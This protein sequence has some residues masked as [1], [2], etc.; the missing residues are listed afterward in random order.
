MIWVTG[1]RGLIGHYVVEFAST[2]NPAK[3]ARPIARPEVE[4]TDFKL[5]ERLF[6]NENP[7]A[8]IHCAALSKTPVCQKD[9]T[10]AREQ[11][12]EVTAFLSDLAADI[13]FLFFS[14]DLVFDGRQGNYRED[15]GVNPLSVY[16]ETKVEAELVV[17]RNPRHAVIRTSLNGGR[18]PTGNRGFNEEMRAAWNRGETTRLFVDE[19]RSP[20]AAI[21]TARATWELLC[22]GATGVYHVAGTQRLSRFQIGE[23]IAA[24]WPQLNPRLEAA[25]LK[26]YKGAPR[27]PDTSLDCAKAQ[28][29][30]SFKLPGLTEWL[31]EHPEMDF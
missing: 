15:A 8:V 27:A 24:R 5:V 10:L 31:R 1:A 19:W 14:T 9:P 16:A 2:L 3:S 30:L 12:V 18:S 26:D 11:N 29:L 28:S 4:L 25:S 6:T 17:L 22:A 23:L 20:I 13:P 7:A 21:E